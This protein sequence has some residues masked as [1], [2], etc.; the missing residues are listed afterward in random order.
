MQS[1]G[2]GL[3]TVHAQSRNAP[4]TKEKHSMNFLTDLLAGIVHFVGWLV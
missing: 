2:N 3:Q 1:A 4:C